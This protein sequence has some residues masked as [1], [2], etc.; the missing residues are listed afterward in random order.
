[1]VTHVRAPLSKEYIGDDPL[2]IDAANVLGFA[3]KFQAIDDLKSGRLGYTWR[4]AILFRSQ[5]PN[6]SDFVHLLTSAASEFPELTTP[7]FSDENTYFGAV[8]IPLDE[9]E[10]FVNTGGG[11]AQN[12]LNPFTHRR[13]P[14]PV[15]IDDG[16]AVRP[17]RVWVGR[18]YLNPRFESG[19]ELELAPRPRLSRYPRYVKAT[20]T[21]AVPALD[22]SWQ[23]SYS[24]VLPL[25]DWEGSS[26][27]VHVALPHGTTPAPTIIARVADGAA[28]VASQFAAGPLRILSTA[29]YQ[30]YSSNAA[31]AEGV[32]S[33]Q[34]LVVLPER[35]DI[36]YYEAPTVLP[37]NAVGFTWYAGFYDWPRDMPAS[38]PENPVT[39]AL[40]AAG[41]GVSQSTTEQIVMPADSDGGAYAP[42][43]S[44]YYVRFL[45]Q[46]A[47]AGAVEGIS[48]VPAITYSPLADIE[49]GAATNWSTYWTAQPDDVEIGGVPHNVFL[50]RRSVNHWSSSPSSGERFLVFRT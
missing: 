9:P 21:A 7:E 2:I 11:F 33:G 26:R 14:D 5:D 42:D 13:L 24:P 41:V 45:V 27:Y 4:Y 19:R 48:S 8:A 37:N 50:N 1:M 29:P 43:D 35:D 30:V 38:H 25:G 49:A 10:A 36:A 31:L 20:T 40:I 3:A 23:K 28:N 32:Y 34:E 22:G 47:S 46:P 39:A 16:I 6:G 12:I 17:H 15:Y 44:R 18:F